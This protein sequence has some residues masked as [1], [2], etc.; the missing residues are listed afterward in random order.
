[1][2]WSLPLMIL[3]FANTILLYVQGLLMDLVYKESVVNVLKL[4]SDNEELQNC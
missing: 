3:V 4:E 2:L 1:M